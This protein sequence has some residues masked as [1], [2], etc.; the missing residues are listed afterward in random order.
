MRGLVGTCHRQRGNKNQIETFR[1]EK[2]D[3]GL[4]IVAGG[5]EGHARGMPEAMQVGKVESFRGHPRDEYLNASSF[6]TLNNMRRTLDN[7]RQESNCERPHS[8]L[9]NGTPAGFRIALGFGDLETN[10]AFPRSRIPTAP[11]T[12]VARYTRF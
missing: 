7:W 3:Q 5:L 6:R 1:L 11:A 12:T 10:K 2:V 4:M 8:S 9:A